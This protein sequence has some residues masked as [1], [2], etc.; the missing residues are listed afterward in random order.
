MAEG[1]ETGGEE[2]RGI[3]SKFY[4]SISFLLPVRHPFI[5]LA[6]ATKCTINYAQTSFVSFIVN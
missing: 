1:E 3:E 6:L 2:W 4:P 5:S